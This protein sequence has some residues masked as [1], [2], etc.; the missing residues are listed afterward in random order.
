MLGAYLLLPPL[1]TSFDFP[2]LP[3]FN[4]NTIP[5]VT[6]LLLC[7]VLLPQRTPLVPQS[8]AARCLLAVFIFSPIF[9]VLNNPEPLI[10]GGEGL[11]GLKVTDA[12]AL[13]INQAILLGGF[14]LSRP[15]LNSINAQR[16]LLVALVIGAL[17]YTLPI[18][19][20]VRLS[21]QINTWVYGFFQHVFSQTIR[22]GGFRPLVFL[23]HGIWVAFFIMT[24]LV[25]A[26]ILWR[27]EPL[28][29]RTRYIWAVVL[30][31]VLLILCK[32]LGPVIFVVFL[33]PAI[34]LLPNRTQIRIAAV[35]A[36]FAILYPALKSA[37]LVPTNTLLSLAQKVSGERAYSLQFR[38]ENEDLLAVRAREKPLFGWGSW[39]RNHLHDPV[40]GSI[41][42]VS[43]GQWIITFGVFGIVG[44]LGEFGLLALPLFLLWRETRHLPKGAVSP[45]IG[46][47]S[48]LLAVNL[49]DLIPNATLT[50]M[51]WLLSGALLG[52]AELL[53]RGRTLKPLDIYGATPDTPA[54][55][56]I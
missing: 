51:T 13:C 33:I 50:P 4:K 54:R 45:Y 27:S 31:S 6:A 17:F 39:G 1:P 55:T 46:P 41:S 20:E 30:F 37:D 2:L 19:I 29:K 7:V 36:F 34:I 23:E 22:A 10:F 14:L 9:T 40:T 12:L 18:L 32:T 47:L 28:A 24:A 49:I 15:L 38:F 3:P 21:P 16:D 48:L 11:P 8:L 42:T 44:F 26:F 5:N 56:L 25:A 43:D 52:H 35:L 53:R